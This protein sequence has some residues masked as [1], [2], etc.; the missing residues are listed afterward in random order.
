ML[1]PRS[2]NIQIAN[3]NIL[4]R[5]RRYLKRTVE[6]PP[7]YE[8]SIDDD[9][10]EATSQETSS[11]NITEQSRSNEPER[12]SRYGKHIKLPLRYRDMTNS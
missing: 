10:I 3:G 7:E 12:V 4:R 5:N 11:S 8:Y 1:A 9:E 6:S 2:Y